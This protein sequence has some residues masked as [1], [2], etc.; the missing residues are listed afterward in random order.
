ME[1]IFYKN[2]T[3]DRKEGEIPQETKAEVAKKDD[4]KAAVK[5]CPKCRSKKLVE[6][7]ETRF[8]FRVKCTNPEC[9][10]IVMIDKQSG[11]VEVSPI[12][13]GL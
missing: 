5:N 3:Y 10:T 6:L 11:A 2:V 4:C 13:A 8:Y 12:P 9:R 1:S 7:A